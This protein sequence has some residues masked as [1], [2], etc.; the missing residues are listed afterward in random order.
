MTHKEPSV[1]DKAIVVASP[2]IGVAVDQATVVW[3]EPYPGA[4]QISD[5]DVL[6]DWLED[7]DQALVEARNG[8]MAISW[9]FALGGLL[10]FLAVLSNAVDAVGFAS[11]RDLTG[12]SHLLKTSPAGLAVCA[13]LAVVTGGAFKLAMEGTEARRKLVALRASYLRRRRQLGG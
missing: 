10:A 3:D 7:V 1:A 2:E 8:V 4:R 5:P 13:I 12:W 6:D 11:L 9:P